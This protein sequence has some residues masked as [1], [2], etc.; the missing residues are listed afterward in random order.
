[1]TICASRCSWVCVKTKSQARS[2]GKRR[3]KTREPVLRLYR[4]AE[5]LPGSKTRSLF[6]SRGSAALQGR[7]LRHSR[8]LLFQVQDRRE[9]VAGLLNAL[10]EFVGRKNETL[11]LAV[12]D[13][14]LHF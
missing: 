10:Q 5:L 9:Q 11:R 7:F 12:F 14:A 6:V 13:R 8:Q 3:S 2:C 4:S 1:M